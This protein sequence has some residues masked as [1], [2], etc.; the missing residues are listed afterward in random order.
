MSLGVWAGI[1]LSI[2][3]I[4]HREGGAEQQQRE[5]TILC[6]RMDLH[7]LA[8]F[9]RPTSSVTV[10]K[11]R[12][13][14][15]SPKE[16]QEP[17]SIANM[18]L[19]LTSTRSATSSAF[20]GQ[21]PHVATRPKELR[22]QALGWQIYPGF[23]TEPMQGFESHGKSTRPPAANN[24]RP[25]KQKLAVRTGSGRVRYGETARER[26]CGRPTRCAG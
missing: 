17:Y 10:V 22:V 13:A 19:Y 20:A 9:T 24:E 12:I 14:S 21:P 15:S 26:V 8:E 7:K 18:C 25:C 3:S 1:L 16:C 2:Y 5:G 6:S 11:Q 4:S 23:D